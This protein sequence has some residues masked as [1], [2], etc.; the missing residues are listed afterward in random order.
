M[1]NA[2]NFLKGFGFIKGRQF[3][4]YILDHA[5]TTHESIT[6]YQEYA[7]HVTLR[8]TNAGNGTY[9]DLLRVVKEHISQGHIIYGIRNPYQCVIDPPHQSD[10]IENRDGSITYKLIG[11]CY[12]D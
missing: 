3:D 2:A 11:H 10:I 9:A 6:R 7:Y 1:P 4:G 12:R 8:F 5:S